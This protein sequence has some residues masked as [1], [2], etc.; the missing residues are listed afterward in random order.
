MQ[1]LEFKFTHNLNPLC[2]KIFCLST[3]QGALWACSHAEEHQVFLQEIHQVW[4]EVWHRGNP[5]T[6]SGTHWRGVVNRNWA[7]DWWIQKHECEFQQ[8]MEQAKKKN[9]FFK[10]AHCEHVWCSGCVLALAET[11]CKGVSDTFFPCSLCSCITFTTWLVYQE[12][13]FSYVP[14]TNTY[15]HTR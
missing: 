5:G 7:S 1:N 12:L 9:F 13:L 14:P 4:R 11:K 10:A 6:S 2:S 15:M 8:E 3:L